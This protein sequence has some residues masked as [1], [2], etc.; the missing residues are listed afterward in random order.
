MGWFLVFLIWWCGASAIPSPAANDN[1]KWKC[2]EI[3]KQPIVECSCDMP[4]T[5][6]CIGDRTA[7]PIISRTLRSLNTS[8]VSLLDCTVQNVSIITGPLLEG[9][10]L[11]GLVVS[12][13]E[14]REVSQ[15]AFQGLG[16][17]LQALGLPNNQLTSVPIVALRFLPELDRLDLSS[18]KLKSLDINSF[19]GLKNLSFIDLSNNIITKIAPYTFTKLLHLKILR[20]RGN[21]LKI[22]IITKINPIPNIEEI[23]LSE[24]LLV[25]PLGPSTFTRMDSLRDLQLSHNLISSIKLG[26]LEGLKN[27]RSLSIHHNQIDV[28]EDH[29]FS[30]LVFL[31][32]LDLSHNRI[33]AVSGAS[34]AHLDKLLDINLSNNFLRAVTADLISPLKSLNTLK[35][36]DNDISIIASDALRNITI[37]KQFSLSENPLNC[38]CSLEEFSIWLTNSVLSKKDKESAVCATPPSLENGLLMEIATENLI[39]GEDEQDNDV[40]PMMSALKNKI[41][42]KEFRYDGHVVNLLW[43]I[44]EEGIPYT[45]DA[46]YVYEEQDMSEILVESMP[47]KC[48]STDLSN[49]TLLEISVPGSID[50]QRLHR[51]RYCLV[52][53]QSGQSDDVSLILGCSDILPLIQNIELKNEVSS[54]NPKVLSIQGNFS[55]DGSL[56]VKAEVYP[57]SKCEVNIVIFEQGLLL[58]QRN[59]NCSNAHYIFVGLTQGPYRAC[60]SIVFRGSPLEKGRSRCIN[61]FRSEEILMSSLDIAMISIFIAFCLILLTLVWGLRKMLLKSKLQTH[62]CFIPPDMEPEQHNRY[63]KLQA[64]TNL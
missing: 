23:D 47:V 31:S 62:Q 21:R 24:N 46:I 57:E 9:V 43:S 4:H 19:K 51:Y 42:I 29:A 17:P 38:D 30:Q 16:S 59:V 36:D 60:A 32:S 18:N 33:V 35:L 53:L 1:T 55:A 28:I 48:N 40:P 63:V 61:I 56:S 34:L 7:L 25:G 10:S 39:C 50:L 12:S 52:L 44:E 45:C 3:A 22:P 13:G 27:L 26:A 54:D 49:P 64:T 6:R 15:A 5:L 58:S 41:S 14:I 2:P 37:L 8:P 20:L 11:H